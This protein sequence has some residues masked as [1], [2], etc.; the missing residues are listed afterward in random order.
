[1]CNSCTLDC[2]SNNILQDPEN[3]CCPQFDVGV[4]ISTQAVKIVDS[5]ANVRYSIR[6]HVLSMF[7]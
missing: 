1:M 3:D 2:I 5:K 7:V 6:V 4:K